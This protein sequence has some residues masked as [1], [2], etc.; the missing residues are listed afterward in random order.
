MSSRVLPQFLVRDPRRRRVAGVC[1]AIADRYRLNTA[2]VR[3]GAL[4]LVGASGIGAI[5]YAVA[6]IVVP[7]R[8]TPAPV[9]TVP[10]RRDIPFSTNAAVL[11][12]VCG[13]LFTARSYNLWF[14]DMVALHLLGGAAGVALL[15]GNDTGVVEL[16]ERRPVRTALG[17]MLIIAGVA[18]LISLSG[19]AWTAA[20]ASGSALITAL[21]AALIFWS[22]LTRLIDERDVE[23]RELALAHERAQVG[24]HLHDGVLQ[25]LALI[26]RKPDDPAQVARLARRQERELRDW[27]HGGQR[28]P[29]GS[30]SQ[31]LKA[32]LHALEDEYDVTIDVVCVGDTAGSEAV[33]AVVGAA[34]EAARNAALHAGVSRVDVFAEVDERLVNVFVRDRGCGFDIARTPPGHHGISESIVG[35]MERAGGS[36]EIVSGPGRGTEVRLSVALP[37]RGGDA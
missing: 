16:G 15:T 14:N 27:L 12:I 11:L 23:R 8:N 13:L 26:Q 7:V 9:P 21:G 32:G 35:R 20:W 31:Q 18:A 30:L 37:R 17:I 4:A 1:A 19:D 36:A 10:Q 34:C 6:W 28:E 25:T 3:F 24:A 29:G 5:I 33:T 22:S 2:V